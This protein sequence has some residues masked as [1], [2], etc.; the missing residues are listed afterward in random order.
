MTHKVKILDGI[1]QVVD[2]AGSPIVGTKVCSI[3]FPTKS[4]D[5]PGGKKTHYISGPGKAVIDVAGQ[6]IPNVPLC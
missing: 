1:P 3:D 5:G 4:V 6:V 2:A